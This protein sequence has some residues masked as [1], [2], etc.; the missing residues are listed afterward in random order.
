MINK[1]R[2]NFLRLNVNENY[3]PDKK[4]VK[5]KRSNHEKPCELIFFRVKMRKTCEFLHFSS[6]HENTENFMN[7]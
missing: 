2:R 6:H 7:S 3:F 4:K 5:K 1:N